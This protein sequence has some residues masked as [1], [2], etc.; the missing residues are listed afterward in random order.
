LKVG[1]TYYWQIRAKDS[2][3]NKFSTG[4]LSFVV[5]PPNVNW[6]TFALSYDLDGYYFEWEVKPATGVAT[7]TAI[8]DLI[9]STSSTF[10]ASSTAV[11]TN[12]DDD[13]AEIGGNYFK[14]YVSDISGFTLAADTNYYAKVVVKDK[15]ATGTTIRTEGLEW[16]IKTPITLETDQ[17]YWNI[18]A[19]DNATPASATVLY[20]LPLGT[21]SAIQ[22]PFKA[23]ILTW[24]YT[25]YYSYKLYMGTANPPTAADWKADISAS[26]NGTLKSYTFSGVAFGT[27]YYVRIDATNTSDPSITHSSPVVQLKTASYTG[28]QAIDFDVYTLTGGATGDAQKATTLPTAL[29]FH[30]TNSS[31]IDTTSGNPYPSLK[32]VGAASGGVGTL[33]TTST[34]LNSYQSSTLKFDFKATVSNE[35]DSFVV[36]IDNGNAKSIATPY[37]PFGYD[38]TTPSNQYASFSGVILALKY[39]A[40]DPHTATTN[41]RV[42]RLYAYTI[43]ADG[44][45]DTDPTTA[46]VIDN[47]S[48]TD[49]DIAETLVGSGDITINQWHTLSITVS[50]TDA[51][52]G[53]A[54]I[55]LDNSTAIPTLSIILANSLTV[56]NSML[57]WGIDRAMVEVAPVV[58][59]IFLDNVSYSINDGSYK[60][61]L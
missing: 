14:V 61:G 39:Y 52:A 2:L 48:G 8:C 3:D 27:T 42:F 9:V 28:G 58:T 53:K 40:D 30:T 12:L 25:P 17:I 36:R 37:D 13:A 10:N 55:Y 21:S 50:I 60:K 31:V 38:L 5:G 44:T 46:S 32:L 51:T 57:S 47:D 1:T 4:V 24:T 26:A 23:N 11:A 19:T 6:S 59:T 54:D 34:T 41:D 15:V 20:P 7:D 22:V 16:K 45:V 33:R 35:L 56:P 43:Q 29:T 18:T 49:P